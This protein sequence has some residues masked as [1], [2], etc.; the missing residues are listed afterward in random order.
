MES[1]IDFFLNDY[2]SLNTQIRIIVQHKRGSGA[3]DRKC[4]ILHSKT[5]G[6]AVQIGP[7]HC[8]GEGPGSSYGYRL[9]MIFTSQDAGL[10]Q[11]EIVNYDRISITLN[12]REGK[13][14][15]Q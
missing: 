13:L 2:P 12:V 7:C 3:F 1:N 6:C 8:M 10:L 15:I 5:S 9:K 4:Q 11:V 14:V